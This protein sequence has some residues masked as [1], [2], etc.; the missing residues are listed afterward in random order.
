MH[1]S[2]ARVGRGTASALL[3][4]IFVVD[5]VALSVK[6]GMAGNIDR[7]ELR[8]VAAGMLV[9][10]YGHQAHRLLAVPGVLS[11]VGDDLY[12]MLGQAFQ[13]RPSASAR[14]PK[15]GITASQA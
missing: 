15:E 8:E 7:G 14:T 3:R 1:D 4:T 10:G 11:I 13:K 2:L 9:N 12:R 6:H 5:A